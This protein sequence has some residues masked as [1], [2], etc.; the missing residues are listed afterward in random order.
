[1]RCHFLLVVLLG[2]IPTGLLAAACGAR[3]DSPLSEAAGRND[4]AALKSLVADAPLDGADL[5]TAL[6]WAARDGAAD[7]IAFL[8][9]R[10]AA[11]DERDRGGNRWTPLQHAVHKEQTGA[12]QAL[13][14]QGADPNAAGPVG[15]TPLFMAADGADPTMVEQLLDAGADPRAPGPGGRTALTQ[16]VSG[17]A[18]W[19]VTD[20]P[21]FGGCRPATVRTLLAHDATLRVPDNPAGHNAV[22]WAR[23][24]D[25]KDV[26]ALIGAAPTKPG[27]KVVA[28]AG[29]IRERLGIPRPRDFFQGTPATGDRPRP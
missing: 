18:L 27:Q 12:V 2:G 4:V 21:L 16:A 3:P 23:V 5:H 28:G 1:M 15:A 19:D 8:V 29:L 17:G 10:G 14:E 11:V 20:R 7:A 9:E 24:H 25:C 13:L 26:L 22:W 6:V